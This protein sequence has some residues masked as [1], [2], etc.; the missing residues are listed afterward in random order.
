MSR[1]YSM[2]GVTGAA[3]R[4]VAL[5]REWLCLDCPEGRVHDVQDDPRFRHRGVDL[6]WE[7]PALPVLGVEVKGDRQG[8][9]RGN[10]FFELVSNVEKDSPGCF[11]YSVA[12][13]LVYVFLDARELHCL[14]LPELRQ[15]FVPRAKQYALKTT[16][17]RTGAHLYTTVGAIVPVREVRAA[18]PEAL[19]VH[20]FESAP[21]AS[22]APADGSRP[23]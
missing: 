23:R 22:T 3:E 12:D 21:S 13:L 6:L 20:R 16:R 10:Y 9:R 8:K 17:T 18:V 5:A 2:R 7:R 15:W 14:R 19:K 11:L 1:S 4:A